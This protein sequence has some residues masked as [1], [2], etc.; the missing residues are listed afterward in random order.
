MAFCLDRYCDAV[1]GWDPVEVA[2]KVVDVVGLTI[3]ATGPSMHVG[4]LC[5][6]EPREDHE[7]IPVEVVGFRDGR[8]LDRKSVV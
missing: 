3:E 8:I 6:V 5:Y 2:G 1:Q 4:D 7:K